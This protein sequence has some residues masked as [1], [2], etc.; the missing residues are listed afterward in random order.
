M[1][2]K[3][4]ISYALI[5]KT[6]VAQITRIT[7]IL[8]IRNE[9]VVSDA[10]RPKLPYFAYKITTPGMAMGEASFDHVSGETFN[11]GQQFKIVVSVNL[12]AQDQDQAY[13]LMFLLQQSLNLQ[14]V[15]EEFRKAG[16]AIWDFGNVV[17]LSILLNTGYEARTQLDVH[18]GIASNLTDDE[19]TIDTAQV[20]GTVDTEAGTEIID[21]NVP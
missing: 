9:P 7:G 17:D 1:S 12:Y 19:G 2:F 14:T 13:D 21:F 8:C 6:I 16:M 20:E 15:M 5:R 11:Y 4:P 18:F 3:P 10:P